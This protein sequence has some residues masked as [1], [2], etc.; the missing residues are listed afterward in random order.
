MT[1]RDY[2]ANCGTQLF[3]GSLAHPQVMSV[4]VVTFD[5]PNLVS[6]SRHV[7]VQEKVDWVCIN[8]QL[9]QMQTQQPT[10]EFAQERGENQ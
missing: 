9:P 8:D 3:S 6:P 10:K 7:W 2:C 5:H 4:K 1:Y